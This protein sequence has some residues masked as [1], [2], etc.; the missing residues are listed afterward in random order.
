MDYRE[1]RKAQIQKLFANFHLDL[2][3]C[4]KPEQVQQIYELCLQGL[5]S[6]EI[7]Q[8]LGVT[9]K[10]VQKTYRRYKFPDLQNFFPPRLEERHDFR[11]GI[12]ADCT[13]HLYKRTP[14]HPYGTKHG[15]YVAV[16][17]LVMEQHL[18]RYLKPNEVVHHLDGNPANNKIENLELF[19]SNSQHLSETL[20]GCCPKWTTEGRKRIRQYASERP[21]DDLGQFVDHKR[22]SIRNPSKTDG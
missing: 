3:G 9:P 15:C 12:K 5:Y 7:A 10:T 21:R 19:E 8:K 11:G 6:H 18:G 20:K 22:E 16:H 2:R 13:G 4:R 17:R 14:G 1:K